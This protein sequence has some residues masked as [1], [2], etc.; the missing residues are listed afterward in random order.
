VLPSASDSHLRTRLV[1]FEGGRLRALAIL[2]VTVLLLSI[3]SVVLHRTP[4]ASDVATLLIVYLALESGLVTGILLALMIGYAGDLFSGESRGLI[5]GSLVL[6]FLILR[7]S[8]VRLTGSRWIP[9]TAISVLATLLSA[10]LR[11]GLEGIVGPGRSTLN[12]MLPALPGLMLGAAL[13][14]YPCYRLLRFIDDRFRS[15]ED[16]VTLSSLVSRR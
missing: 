5:S 11:L 4:L 7:L 8:V 6:L 9:I 15:R 10:L 12:A 1:L 16:E 3:Q 14:G 2:G 13:F